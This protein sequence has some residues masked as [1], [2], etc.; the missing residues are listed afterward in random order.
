MTT[1]PATDPF[2]TAAALIRERVLVRGTSLLRARDRLW[3]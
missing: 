3:G 1:T 2:T